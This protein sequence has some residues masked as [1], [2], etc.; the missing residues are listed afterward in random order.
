MPGFD[1]NEIEHSA[2]GSEVTMTTNVLRGAAP[3][4]RKLLNFAAPALVVGVLAVSQAYGR[5][6]FY[7]K[8]VIGALERSIEA[9]LDTITA[10]LVRQVQLS[11]LPRTARNLAQLRVNTAR[12]QRDLQILVPRKDAQ[13]TRLSFLA[14]RKPNQVSQ[15]IQAA[16]LREIQLV[17][18]L[19]RALN[20]TPF[21]TA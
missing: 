8:G 18:A 15:Y 7:P 11:R 2:T 19:R 13:L 1:P 5:L 20:I 9:K 16:T 10:D 17:Q 21:R 3:V 6:P 4:A 12:L 14:P